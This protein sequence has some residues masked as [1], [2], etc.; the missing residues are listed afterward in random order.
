ME[1]NLWAHEGA[2]HSG[3]I[4]TGP[5]RDLY[6]LYLPEIGLTLF[7]QYFKLGRL[8]D[9][10]LWQETIHTAGTEQC[11]QSQTTEKAECT[12]VATG[13]VH[14]FDFSFPRKPIGS[15]GRNL[16]ATAGKILRMMKRIHW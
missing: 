4:V 9:I 11:S 6:D 8:S 15:S 13:Q 12:Y 16:S 10:C 5:D 3:Y 1:M 7:S 14:L 2:C